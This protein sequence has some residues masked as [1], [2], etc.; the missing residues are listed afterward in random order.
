M[1]VQELIEELKKCPANAE[2]VLKEI[3]PFMHLAGVPNK[4]PLVNIRSKLT[5][6]MQWNE[7]DYKN[8]N[9]FQY[10]CLGFENIKKLEKI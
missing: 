2:V 1:T 9:L 7:L 4:T 8:E 5:D 6:V 3:T 10:V